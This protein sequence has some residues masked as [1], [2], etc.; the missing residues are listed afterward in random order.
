MN[1]FLETCCYLIRIS[2]FLF[3]VFTL[4]VP[5]IS[6]Y[7]DIYSDIKADRPWKFNPEDKEDMKSIESMMIDKN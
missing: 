1:I 6:N 3:N 5:G 2:C 4:S 7:A